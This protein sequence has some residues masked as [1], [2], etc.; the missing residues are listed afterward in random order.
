[1]IVTVHSPLCRT[2]TNSVVRGTVQAGNSWKQIAQFALIA[3]ISYW[4]LFQK[5]SHNDWP[6]FTRYYKL[7]MRHH[8]LKLLTVLRIGAA[9]RRQTS[10][11]Q[12]GSSQ[13]SKHLWARKS[14]K[15]CSHSWGEWLQAKLKL[16]KMKR[17]TRRKSK[18]STFVICFLCI[19]TL[20]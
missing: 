6:N 4:W 5:C 8:R 7:W 16:N 3:S 11:V 10:T 9:V 15:A 17:R 19:R 14:R 20:R 1:M 12:S 13:V 18:Y 2:A